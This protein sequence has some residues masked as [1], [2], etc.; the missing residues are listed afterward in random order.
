M[1]LTSLHIEKENSLWHL[2]VRYEGKDGNIDATRVF[3]WKY[4]NVTE[5]LAKAEELLKVEQN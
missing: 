4:F 1:K 3:T 2:E 5:L